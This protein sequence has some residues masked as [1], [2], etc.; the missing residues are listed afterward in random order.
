MYLDKLVITGFKSFV[1]KTTFE[2]KHPFTAIVGPNG[3]GKTNVVDAL[4][5]V[6]GE[7]SSKL[8]R[9][10]KAGDAIFAGSKKLARLG[11]A[12]VDLHLNNHDNRLNLDYP[13]VVISRKIYRKGES[14]YFINKSKVRL[15]D[16]IMLLAKANFGQKSYGVIGQGMIT[17]ILNANPQDRKDFFDEA[18]GVKEFQIKRDQAIN[19]LIRTE[20]NLVRAEDLLQEIEPRL[21]SL[22]RQVRKLE[23]RKVIEDEL[24]EIQLQYYGSY[25][26][27]LEDKLKSIGGQKKDF[28]V[29]KQDIDKNIEQTQKLIDE[30]A[31]EESRGSLYKKLQQVYNDSL[32]QKNKLLK[33]QVVLKGKL[34]VEQEKQGELNLVWLERKNEDIL[35]SISKNKLEIEHLQSIVQQLESKL[36]T[37]EEQTQK[38]NKDFKE[39]EY[40]LLKAKEELQQKMEVLSVPEVRERLVDIFARQENFLKQLLATTDLDTF[41]DV[42]KQAEKV[43]KEMANLL[44]ELHGRNNEEINAQQ[45][46]IEILEKQLQE[47]TEQKE[48][49][50]EDISE[51]KINIQGK[52]DKIQLWQENIKKEKQEVEDLDKEINELKKKGE[53]KTDKTKQLQVYREENQALNDQLLKI[54]EE[55]L[56]TQNKVNKFNE[57]EEFKKQELLKLQNQSRDYQNQLSNLV[58]QT[59]QTD[60]ELTRYETKKEDL[61]QEMSKEVSMDEIA[62]IKKWKGECKNRNEISVRIENLKHQLEL[63]GSIDQETILEHET[64]SERFDFLKKQS[65]DLTATISKLD[66]IIDELDDT[67]KKQFNK[68]FKAIADNFAK[69]FKI[70]F[71][72]GHAKLSLITEEPKAEE[73]SDVNREEAESKKPEHEY[74]GKKKKKQRIVSGIEI[75]ATPPGKKVKNVH[76]L[77]GGEKSMTAISLICAIIAANT[78][79]F[80][81]LDEVEAALDEANSDKFSAIIRKLSKK[82]QFVTITHN[83]STMHQADILYGVTMGSEGTSNILSVKIEEAQKMT[84]KS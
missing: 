55:L 78:P 26:R 77:S 1:K 21:R 83:R 45:K 61:E 20:E 82:T 51:L 30:L 9:T 80:V 5:W 42:Q 28:L 50:L 17:D 46:K 22:R 72:G 25:W 4:R 11:M 19:K 14:E 64:T 57:E 68:S 33:E 38:V 32:N 73:V 56:N 7:Q 60:I 65:K 52:K 16:I 10:K 29:S 43:T 74:I 36:D 31:A 67:I 62:V 54:E 39:L 27:E 8:L 59:N 47:K 81:I 2:F 12:Q 70:I 76:T 44:D 6:M 69:Y 3:G 79:P 58:N 41:K 84:Q 53:A 35:H 15:N 71:D 48:K 40:Q 23:K 24:K 66:H 63:I 34:E 49:V 37:Q 18:T 13:E 75:E